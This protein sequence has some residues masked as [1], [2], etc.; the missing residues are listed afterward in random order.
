MSNE[1]DSRQ[2]EVGDSSTYDRYV[3]Q[4]IWIRRFIQASNGLDKFLLDYGFNFLL[5]IGTI[6]WCLYFIAQIN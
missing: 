6:F 4:S 5:R 2:T 3:F 1:C